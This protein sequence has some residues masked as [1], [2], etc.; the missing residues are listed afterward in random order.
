[1]ACTI[2]QQLDCL[3]SYTC[4]KDIFQA[5]PGAIYTP[6]V[7]VTIGDINITM[8][9]KSSPAYKNHAAISSFTYGFEPGTSSFGADI[10]I[11]DSG[12]TAYRDIIRAINK[13]IT[14]A[15]TE[16][17]G[18]NLDFGWILQDCNG[19]L[20]TTWTANQIT[21]TKI[22]GFIS[23]V[24]QTFE[25]AIIKLKFKIRAPTVQSPEVIQDAV[26]GDQANKR[27]L[28][29]AIIEVF[30]KYEPKYKGVR[31]ESKDSDGKGGF[32]EFKF[33]NSDGGPDGPL[34]VWAMNQQNTVSAVRSWLNSVTTSND[35]GVLLEYDSNTYEMVLKES[36]FGQASCQYNLGTYIVNGGNCSPVLEFN[37]TIKWMPSASTGAVSGSATSAGGAKLTPVEE[38][39]QKAGSIAAPAQQ[40][41]ESHFR[42]PDDIASKSA[43]AFSA[44]Y[45][46]NYIVETPYAAF[47]AQLKIMGDP[48][49]ADLVDFLGKEVSIVVLNPF[50]TKTDCTWI[51]EP[52]CNQ[53]LSNKHYLIK[54]VSHQITE[55]SFVTTLHVIMQLP[56]STLPADST[57]GGGGTESYGDTYGVSKATVASDQ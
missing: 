44:Q 2:L 33:K 9:N 14:N 4:M 52:T 28:K 8:G 30:T 6:Y 37:P 16:A 57:L 23:E 21:G 42:N 25:N 31:F 26:I 10:E 36:P 34:G 56:N 27:T 29:S 49:F 7:A 17:A 46:A 22:T 15:A 51:S 40:Q 39:A 35:L 11:V 50:S 24:E 38:N 47:D 19:K 3:T 53:V 54:G 5:Y 48:A 32:K 18:I 41:H 13:T 45:D 12:G 20:T 43:K 1:M 55:G